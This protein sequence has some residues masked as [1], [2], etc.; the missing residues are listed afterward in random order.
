MHG[1]KLRRSGRT[2]CHTFTKLHPFQLV[3]GCHWI[4]S[5]KPWKTRPVQKN[6][7]L[8]LE[9]SLFAEKKRN[10]SLFS[11]KLNLS[12]RRNVM[13]RLPC[14]H[15]HQQGQRGFPTTFFSTGANNDVVGDH[16]WE[17][18]HFKQWQVGGRP[19]V[20]ETRP[21]LRGDAAADVW[22]CAG[23]PLLQGTFWTRKLW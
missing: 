21:K 4:R 2:W 18:L 9:F 16:V 3:A 23:K 19:M 6:T 22:K 17:H 15:L 7:W 14:W 10:S 12:K 11:K 1:P 8:T 20:R 13:P 5:G